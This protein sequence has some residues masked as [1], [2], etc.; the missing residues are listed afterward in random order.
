[1]DQW[2]D[3]WTDGQTDIGQTLYTPWH[4]IVTGVHFSIF[5]IITTVLHSFLIIYI[6][7]VLSYQ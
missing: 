2:T 6:L 7:I 3:G 4:I 1:M 5:Y